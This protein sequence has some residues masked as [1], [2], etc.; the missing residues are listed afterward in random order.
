[1]PRGSWSVLVLLAAGCGGG[2]AVTPPPGG[3]APAIASFAASKTAIQAAQH[4]DLTAVFSDGAGSIDQGVGAVQTGVAVSVAPAVTTTYTLT[5]SAAGKTSVTASVLVNVATGAACLGSALM[6][7]LGKTNVLVGAQ[8]E[9]V[10]AAKAPFDARYLYLSGGYFDGTAPCTSCHSGCTTSGKSCVNGACDWWGCWQD[11]QQPPGAYARS[12]IATAKAH[13]QIPWFTYYEELQASGLGEG[14]A[15]LA[16]LNDNALMTR[17]FADFRFLLQQI[18][19]ET[20][21]VHVE[22]DLWGY[23]EQK[24]ADPHLIPAKVQGANATDCATQEN[25]VAGFAR[26]LVAMARKY[27]PHARIGLHASEWA[28]GKEVFLNTSASFDVAGE[29]RK[30][31]TFLTA[32]GAGNGDF[33]VVDPSDRDAGFYASQGQNTSWDATNQTLPHFHQALDWTKA[34]AESVQLPAILWQIPVGN[35]SQNNT[36]THWKDNRVDYFFAHPGELASAHAAGMLFGA[37]RDDQTNPETDG[38]NL[39]ARTKA[40]ATAGG[41]AL[42]P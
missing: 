23:C 1:M 3:G 35:A 28:S 41:Q 8:M 38:G 32:A 19:S 34:L 29:A 25:S 6:Q 33:I 2:G 7:G 14:A 22:P 36:A 40:L 31:G 5:V 21:F 18:G 15:Q 30:V 12:F 13:A 39:V 37:G 9:D 17:Y 4:V 24:N 16:G 26:C 10:T 11:D 27:A 42:C 20:A